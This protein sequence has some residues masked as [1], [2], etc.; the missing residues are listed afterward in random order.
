MKMKFVKFLIFILFLSACNT[1]YAKRKPVISSKPKNTQITTGIVKESKNKPVI[2]NSN[3]V[4]YEENLEATSAV[5]VTPEVIR[6]YIEDYKNIAMIEMQ[7]YNIPASI[8][9]AQGILE[10][11]SGQGRLARVARNHFG[12][13]CH[14]G[15]EG[16]FVTHDDDDKGECF[17]KYKKAEDSFEDHSLFLVNRPRYLDLFSLKPDDYRGWAH[18]LKKAGY[19]TDPKYASKLIFLISKYELHK[20]DQMVLGTY[21]GDKSENFVQKVTDSIPSKE[22]IATIAPDAETYEV[23]AGDTLY[24][25]SKKVNISVEKLI[26]INNLEGHNIQIGEILKIK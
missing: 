15:W 3:S 19:A 18:G 12:I 22:N 26:E 21:K 9:L 2:N 10:S 13:K 1:R 23:Q 11:G 25:I 7:R 4:V 16:E 20:Y 24:S 8:T 6:Q 5:K 17:R 14:L